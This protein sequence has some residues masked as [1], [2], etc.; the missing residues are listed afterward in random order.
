MALF[1]ISLGFL[2]VI[3]LRKG[4]VFQRGRSQTLL[5]ILI[6]EPDPF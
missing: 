6:N 2:G 5:S 3:L 4:I 1:L